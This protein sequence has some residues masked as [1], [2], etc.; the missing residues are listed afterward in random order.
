M[1]FPLRVTRAGIN[2]DISKRVNAEENKKGEE[3]VSWEPGIRYQSE[4]FPLLCLGVVL[5]MPS[6]Q[7]SLLDY[8]EVPASLISRSGQYRYFSTE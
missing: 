8:S 3:G 6:N 2:S 4:S 5:R 1:V 7:S